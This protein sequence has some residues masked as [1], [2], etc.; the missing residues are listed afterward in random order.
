MALARWPPPV[1]LDR[2][3]TLSGLNGGAVLLFVELLLLLGVDVEF[4]FIAN[5]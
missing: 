3:R 1:S 4:W 2:K 5:S